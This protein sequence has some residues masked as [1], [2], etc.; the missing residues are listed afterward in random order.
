ML[1]GFDIKESTEE[2]FKPTTGNG[3]L[4]EISNDD[5]VRLSKAKE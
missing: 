2:N 1:G 4:H 3:S 5:G